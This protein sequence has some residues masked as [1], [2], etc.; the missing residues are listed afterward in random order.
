MLYRVTFKVVRYRG[1]EVEAEIEGDAIR[2]AWDRI[3]AGDGIG[4]EYEDAEFE[5]IEP[6]KKQWWL[7]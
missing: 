7:F 2:E 4:F 5:S 1:T 3:T 6:V